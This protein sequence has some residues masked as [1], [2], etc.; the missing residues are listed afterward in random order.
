M[1]SFLDVPA[2]EGRLT[3]LANHEPMIC[4]LNEG[5]VRVSEDE[6]TAEERWEIARG[7]MEITRDGVTLLVREIRPGSTPS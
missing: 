7:T 5:P 3:V 6:E 2:A 4:S 1:V